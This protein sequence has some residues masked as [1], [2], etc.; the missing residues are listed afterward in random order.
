MFLSTDFPLLRG[1]EDK[2]L[3]Q[4]RPVQ[5]SIVYPERIVP[6]G[7]H[8]LQKWKPLQLNYNPF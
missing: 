5:V 1:P 8:S 3:I 4:S 7:N 2:M 6:G